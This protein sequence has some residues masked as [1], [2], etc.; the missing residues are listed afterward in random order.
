MARKDLPEIWREKRSLYGPT[1]EMHRLQH[2]IDQMF[3]DFFN[4]PSSTELFSSAP[5]LDE[6]FTPLCDCDET[7]THYLLN[8]DLP[9]VKKDEVKIDL[10][11]NQLSVSGERKSESKSKQGRERFYGSFYRS[12]TLPSNIDAD[13][14]EANFENGVL[15]VSIPKTEVSPGKQIPIKEGKML[16]SKSEKETK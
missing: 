5:M 15:Q 14:I 2:R 4:L 3:E 11:D 6:G 10:K 1:R 12:F 8:F 13:K 9:G 7:D 16:T